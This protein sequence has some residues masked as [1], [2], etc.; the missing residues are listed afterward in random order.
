[1]REQ[2]CINESVWEDYEK[3]KKMVENEKYW[4][5]PSIYEYNII[6][7]TPHHWL[8]GENGDREWVGI[9]VEGCVI[10]TKAQYIQAWSTKVKPSLVL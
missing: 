5:S 2:N 7:C 8:L 4:N 1:V 6:N 3:I 10:F 9:C